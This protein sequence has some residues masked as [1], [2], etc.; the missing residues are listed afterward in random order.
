MHRVA[1][2][3]LVLAGLFLL[4]FTI[5]A[6]SRPN[7]LWITSEDNGPQLGCYGDSYATTPYLD[8]LAARGMIYLNVWSV[9]PVCAPARTAIISGMYPSS[10]GS[11]HM[12]S[13]VRLPPRMKLFPQFLREAGYYCSNNS[14]EDYNLIKPGR[15]WDDSSTNAHWRQRAPAQPFFAVFNFT[16]SHES[17]VRKRPHTFKHDPAR[18]PL[19]AYH[20]D[21][22][23]VRQDW[24]HYYDQI[25]VIDTKAG[26]RLREIEAAGVA[27][28]TIVFYYGDHGAGLP[29]SKRSVCNS[30]LRVPL[31]VYIPPKFRHL[32]PKDYAPGGRSERLVSFVDLAPTVL[33][34]ASVRPPDYFQGT[35]FMGWYARS[36]PDFLHGL[37]GRMDERPDLARS[38]FDGRYV[39]VRNFMPHLPAGQHVAYMFETP[40][41]RVW[42]KLFDAGDL[43]PEQRQFW[44]PKPSEEL[45]DL[46]TDPSEVHNLSNSPKHRSVL[47]RMRKAQRDQARRIRDVGLLPEDEIHSRSVGSTPYEVGHNRQ[48]PFSRI[49]A[50]AELASSLDP[51]VTPKLRE[52]LNDAD[53]AVR[54]WGAIGLL[55]RGRDSVHSSSVPLRFALRDASWSVRV[56]AA[57]ALAKFGDD[58]DLEASLEVLIEAANIQRHGLYIAVA[59]LNALDGLDRRAARVKEKIAAL[60]DTRGDVIEKLKDYISRLKEKTLADLN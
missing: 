7:I 56:A 16:Q 50:A 22:P 47:R 37:R 53:S 18:A 21:T 33:S 43:L 5:Q 38:V 28:D 44:M 34:L 51:S 29:R 48:F 10:T 41:T 4:P 17:Q 24:T 25:T 49:F 46:Q 23:E 57:E 19:P 52:L 42:K 20:P 36:A 8:A 27:E 31:I 59:A 9:S 35:A 15:V 26:E 13:E 6:A 3:C 14:K 32:A 30:G 58:S 45:Y 2:Y 12:R 40:T 60:P 11:E 54:Y 55:M 1:A 39:Y